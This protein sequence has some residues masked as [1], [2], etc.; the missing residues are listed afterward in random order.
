[1]T[2]KK[3]LLQ[4]T[5]L[6]FIFS[7]VVVSGC[8]KE[9]EEDLLLDQALCH[10]DTVSYS[11]HIQPYINAHCMPCHSTAQ[12]EGGVIMETWLDVAA[13]AAGGTLLGV[14]KHEP[15]YPAMPNNAPKSTDCA[16]EGF[17]RWVSQGTLNN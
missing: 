6:G 5:V 17:E 10:V 8:T 13:I 9:N 12:Q 4:L 11:Q 14:I 3:N 7:L 15:G 16:I 1:M 2:H